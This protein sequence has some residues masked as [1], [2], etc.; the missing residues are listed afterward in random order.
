MNYDSDKIIGYMN[1]GI[2][3]GIFAS[4]SDWHCVVGALQI[5]IG[6]IFLGRSPK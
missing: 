2:G 3:I 4:Y 5:V 1:L 6:A